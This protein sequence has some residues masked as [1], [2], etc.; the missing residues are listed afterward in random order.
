M[1]ICDFT[2]KLVADHLD[3]LD[4]NGP[5]A[6]SCDDTKL[7]A[8]YRLYWDKEQDSYVLIGGTDGPLV[9]MDP[10]SVQEVIDQAKA[11]KA[12]KVRVS[13]RILLFNVSNI[14]FCRIGPALVLNDSCAKSH[15]HHCCCTANKRNGCSSS[16][17]MPQNGSG[18][19]I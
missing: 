15:S 5:V 16:L 12:T 17:C 10:D 9:V 7:F 8:T 14:D 6:L 18:W 11:Q 1:E 3:A 2:F 13:F 4:Y 19:I